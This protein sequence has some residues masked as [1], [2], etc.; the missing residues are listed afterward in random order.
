MLQ[1]Y[2][3]TAIGVSSRAAVDLGFIKLPYTIIIASILII[4]FFYLSRKIITKKKLTIL[5]LVIVFVAVGQLTADYYYGHRFYDLQHNWHY[6]AY[7]IFSFIAFRRFSVKPKPINKT[8]FY[9]FIMALIISAFDEFIQIYISGRV[10]DLSDVAKDLWGNMAGTVFVFFYLE[11]GKGFPNYKLRC[12]KVKEYFSNPF[13]LLCLEVVFTYIFLFVSSQITDEKYKFNVVFITIL[14]FLIAF[15]LIH[16]G[17][18]KVMRWI[19]RSFLIIITGIVL[20][21]AFLGKANMKYISPNIV[22]Y[23]GIPLVYFDY[24]IFPGGGFR[25]VDKKEVF[26]LRDK[27]KIENLNP[28]ILLLGTGSK[29][30]GGKGWQDNEATEMVYNTFKNKV[31]QIIKLPTKQACITFNRLKRQ[32]KRV[33]FI[34][35]NQ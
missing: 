7:G 25:T 5:A 4:L 29:G 13:S 15:S 22:N 10:F 34:I 1:N 19:I 18:N 32:N 20:V 6:I 9:I 35:H 14:I 21:S 23:N 12:K 31:Y 27:Q 17:R 26:T 16:L 28:D 3:Q 24:M 30:N 8:I 11:G 2:L 33:L